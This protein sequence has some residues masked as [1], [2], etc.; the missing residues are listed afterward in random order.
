MRDFYVKFF[1]KSSTR[2]TPSRDVGRMREKEVGRKGDKGAK[3]KVSR[4]RGF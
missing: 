3:K 1:C 2:N 4:G